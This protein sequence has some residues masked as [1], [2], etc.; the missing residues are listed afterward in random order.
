MQPDTR[1]GVEANCI[2]LHLAE[3]LI[4]DLFFEAGVERRKRMGPGSAISGFVL[5][6]GVDP[7]IS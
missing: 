4:G 3:L 5:T 6:C 2:L 7:T 1:L